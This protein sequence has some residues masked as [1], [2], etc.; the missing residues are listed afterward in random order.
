MV[1][2]RVKKVVAV[3]LLEA[4]KL[5]LEHLG[6][7][8]LEQ[9]GRARP[10]CDDLPRVYGCVRRLRDHLQRCVSSYRDSVELEFESEA[11]GLLVASCRRMVEHLEFQ[12]AQRAMTADEQRW[13]REKIELVSEHAVAIAAKP[14]LELPL[15]R[16]GERAG[17]FTRALS[18]RLGDKVFG[19]VN[20]RE[21]IVPPKTAEASA[22]QGAPWFADDDDG[23]MPGVGNAP[24]FDVSRLQDP[25]LRSLVAMDLAALGRAQRDGDYRLAA[26][27]LA[28]VAETVLLDHVVPRRREFELE[29]TPDQWD[30][31]D[32]LVKSLGDTAA[33][34][35]IAFASHLF[36]ARKM[37]V[38]AVQMT[39]PM[40][41]TATSFD[42]LREFT[43]RVIDVLG[44]GANAT[45]RAP[46]AA[47]TEGRP[48]TG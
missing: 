1:Q 16:I 12:L 10:V 26:V 7:R 6:A 34:K 47:D 25:R 24:L 14:L 23:P 18:S 39:T 17:E 41:V 19:D 9:T 20:M 8:R 31:A 45:Y 15:P 38:P 36:K 2:L 5:T 4:V 32:V 11:A 42:R 30:L 37:L 3:C 40:V 46:D 28:G 44:Y 22:M 35:D 21:K 13:A 43:L 27:M 33:K 29:G 48:T